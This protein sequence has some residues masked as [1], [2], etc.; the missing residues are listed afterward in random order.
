VIE[1]LIESTICSTVLYAGFIAFFRRSRSY[2]ANRIILLFSVLF[3]L[4]APLLKFST[5]NAVAQE[6]IGNDALSAAI[7]SISV[8]SNLTMSS[9]EDLRD[10]W[11]L[12]NVFTLYALISTLLLGRFCFNLLS[13][14]SG[15]FVVEKVLHKGNRLALVDMNVGPFSF[16]RTVYVNKESFDN[17][18]IDHDLI[19]HESGHV[20]QLHSIDI[21]FIELVQV[22]CWFNPFVCLF[23]KLVK[24]NHEYL[25]D[26]FVVTSGSN[27]TDYSNKIIKYST[28]DKTLNLASGFNYSLIKNRLI[29]LSTND[30]KRPI[31]YRLTMFVSIVVTLFITTAF[32]NLK[33]PYPGIIDNEKSGIFY[34]DTLFWSGEDQKIY[35]KGQVKVNYGR[36][37][38]SGQGSFSF[39][40]KVNRLVINGTSAT[41]NSS[42]QLSGMKCEINV[43]SAEEAQKKYG[44]KD[45]FGVVEVNTVK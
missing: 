28:Q 8:I 18:E 44:T 31:F 27:K 29:M 25:A 1:Y 16:F 26:E 19:L 13:L 43:L 17:G 3:F 42:F 11:S 5:S 23:K 45:N 9:T 37:N 35:L 12:L 41:L 15:K 21:I 20:K 4:L 24:T 22:F 30:Q 33:T 36:N 34:A 39:L 32:S 14:L 10:D 2:H 38:M 40:G 6:I 7:S